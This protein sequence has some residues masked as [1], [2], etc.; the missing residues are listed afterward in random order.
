[1]SELFLDTDKA[2]VY[3]TV[4]QVNT[5]SVYGISKCMYLVQALIR[6]WVIQ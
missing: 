6:C 1:M 2:C 5:C 3:K 4:R